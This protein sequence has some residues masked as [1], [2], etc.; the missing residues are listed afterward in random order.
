MTRRKTVDQ[1][2]LYGT[3]DIRRILSCS[4]RYAIQLMH[5]FDY[6]KQSFKI[7]RNWKVPVDI[8]NSW[9]RRQMDLGGMI[10]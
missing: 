5:M 8:F 3:R 4:D 10:R 1:I 9:L 2:E 7:G 6:N